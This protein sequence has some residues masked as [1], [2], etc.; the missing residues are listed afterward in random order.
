MSR[1]GTPRPFTDANLA[2]IGFQGNKGNIAWSLRNV[3]KTTQRLLNL[4][5]Q[6]RDV[7][8]NS[9]HKAE[10]NKI[11]EFIFQHYKSIV[12][13]ETLPANKPASKPTAKS[14]DVS[15]S[16]HLTKEIP[17]SNP[18][19]KA[20]A[21]STGRTAK[22]RKQTA[23]KAQ[24]KMSEQKQQDLLIAKLRTQQNK[25]SK[26]ESKAAEELHKQLANNKELEYM[27]IVGC[28]LPVVLYFSLCVSGRQPKP[29]RNS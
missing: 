16:I 2:S 9:P 20:P 22:K 19:R 4:M 25:A 27:S 21:R 12:G 10:S 24:E 23:K 15:G 1:R 28:I 5:Q 7:D 17:A 11:L 26:E 14:A 29:R 13:G 18:K 6:C 3:E 8:A